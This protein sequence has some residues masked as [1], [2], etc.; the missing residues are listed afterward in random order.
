MD[1][2]HKSDD[3]SSARLGMCLHI[4]CLERA[5]NIMLRLLIKEYSA[6][7]CRA[8]GVEGLGI[9]ELLWALGSGFVSQR[10]VQ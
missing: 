1:R 8:C 10:V 5:Q 9:Q 7:G 6:F 4:G 3:R 2:V